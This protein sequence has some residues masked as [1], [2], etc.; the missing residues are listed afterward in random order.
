[1]Q[2]SKLVALIL[3]LSLCSCVFEVKEGIYFKSNF[4]GKCDSVYVRAADFDGEL[5]TIELFPTDPFPAFSPFGPG[6]LGFL[7][8]ALGVAISPVFILYALA[9][10]PFVKHKESPNKIP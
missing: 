8:F 6:G 7:D 3:L 1:M 10:Y 4:K 2:N 5:T 9:T